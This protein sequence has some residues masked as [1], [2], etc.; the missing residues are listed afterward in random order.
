[1]KECLISVD[2]EATGAVPGHYSMY[3]LGAIA[4][5]TACTFERQ[6]ALLPNARCSRIALQ[7]VGTTKA[8]LKQ[9]HRAIDPDVAMSEFAKWASCQ[10]A[11]GQTPVFVANNAPFDW[12]FVAWY[13][14]ECGIKNPF[15]HAA[16]DMKAYFMGLTACSWKEATLAN[17]AA[18]AGIEFKKLPHR[19]LEDAMIQ[20]QIFA[21]LLNPKRNTV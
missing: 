5:N 19:A 8:K 15:G 9:R 10:C 2:I 20:S 3:E 11:P 16:L 6:I 4:L 21:Q 12:M 17:M 1:M 14:A 7:A 18:H 13:F